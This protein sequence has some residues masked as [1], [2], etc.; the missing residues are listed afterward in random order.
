MENEKDLNKENLIE[1][2]KMA[3]KKFDFWETL[4]YI[5]LAIFLI[6]AI[7]KTFGVIQSPEWLEIGVPALSGGIAIG[8]F[9]QKFRQFEKDLKDIA[10][11]TNKIYDKCPAIRE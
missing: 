11:K 3:K 6:W 4:F 9:Y 2:D 5:A 1:Q 8:S 10:S 7:L